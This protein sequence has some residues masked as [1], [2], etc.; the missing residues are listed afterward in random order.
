MFLCSLFFK[1]HFEA[2]ELVDT[3][4]DWFI[5]PLFIWLIDVVN[6]GTTLG[7]ETPVA[8]LVWLYV[9]RIL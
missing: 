5:I 6:I 3:C 8:G 4:I 9:V 7:H 2:I 1:A